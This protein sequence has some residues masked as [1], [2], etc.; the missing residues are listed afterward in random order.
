MNS[1][2]KFMLTL[3]LLAIGGASACSLTDGYSE[4]DALNDAEAT[5]TPF[6]IALAGEYKTF[7]NSEMKDMMDYPDSL[8]FARKGLAAANGDAIMPEPVSDW[9]LNEGDI[10]ELQ[11]ARNR[12]VTVFDLGAR[13]VA[14]ELSAYAQARFDCWIEDQEEMWGVDDIPCRAQ[15]LEALERLEGIVEPAPVAAPAPEPVVE[16]IPDVSEPMQAEDAVYLVFFDWDKSVL[17]SGAQSV[18]D[19]VAA[20]ARKFPPNGI[21]VVGHADT[22]GSKTYNKKLSVKRANAIKN[23]L[24]ERGLNPSIITTD[25]RGESEL[26]V[27]TADDVREPANRRGTI[28]FQ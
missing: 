17:T 1:A 11:A 15:F 19:S 23:A 27:E 18:L 14:P 12:L 7:S 2:K 13:E 28:T 16:T 8:H 26:M 22:S 4:L 10:V 20:E 5:G 3:G 24:V 21:T 25:S 6:T 9:N